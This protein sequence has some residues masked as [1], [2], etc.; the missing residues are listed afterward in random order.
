M[1]TASPA[2]IEDILS[3]LNK[4]LLDHP[5]AR[6]YSN[7]TKVQLQQNTAQYGDVGLNCVHQFHVAMGVDQPVAPVMP[8]LS[9]MERE[10]IR[11][12]RRQM[13][14]LAKDLAEAAAACGG[15]VPIIRLQLIQEE[16]SELAVAIEYGDQVDAL[17]ALGDLSYVVD[18]SYLSMGMAH[19][20]VPAILEI[21]DSNMTKLCA[22]GKPVISESGRVMKGPNYRPPDLK[23]VLGG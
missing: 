23:E 11:A 19:Y 16:L 2:N 9:Q 14:H 6:V 18:G 12:Y 7:G 8:N 3:L 10:Y 21:H 13:E 5:G 22:D 20:K 1:V 4:Y 15:S 17:D